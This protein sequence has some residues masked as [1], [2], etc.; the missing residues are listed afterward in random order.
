M[1]VY[2]FIRYTVIIIII[3]LLFFSVSAFIITLMLLCITDTYITFKIIII[4][5]TGG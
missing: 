2:I 1:N 5:V 4:S 3:F